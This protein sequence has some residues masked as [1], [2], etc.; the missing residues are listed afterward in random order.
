M[1]K[2]DKWI[3]SITEEKLMLVLSSLIVPYKGYGQH[4]GS[5]VSTVTSQQQL[6]GL[7]PN[8]AGHGF[9]G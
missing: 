7:E 3:K 5:V 9:S 6:P 1:Q 4:G 8:L 2:N